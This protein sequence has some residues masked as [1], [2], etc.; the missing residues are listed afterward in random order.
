MVCAIL[1]GAALLFG[2]FRDLF[3]RRDHLKARITDYGKN[4]VEIASSD[5]LYFSELE[6]G[7]EVFLSLNPPG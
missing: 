2:R 1:Y 4:W 6:K 7:S 3:L 5:G